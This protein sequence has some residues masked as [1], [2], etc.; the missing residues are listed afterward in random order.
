MDKFILSFFILGLTI[1][2][3]NNQKCPEYQYLNELKS[4]FKKVHDVDFTD[5]IN[6][7]KIFYLL[8]IKSCEPCIKLNLEMLSGLPKTKL[9]EI[10][11]LIVGDTN[12]NSLDP[13]YQK[14]INEIKEKHM[15]IIDSESLIYRY[16]TGLALPILIKLEDGACS[17]YLQIEDRLVPQAKKIIVNSLNK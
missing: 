9:S 14:L 3:C 5:P 17:T 8:P 13:E 12:D 10:L 11:V 6:S 1:N 16:E 2:S 15:A 4:Y 7:N